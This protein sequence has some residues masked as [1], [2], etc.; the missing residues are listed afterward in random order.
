[1]FKQILTT[2]F[3]FTK[4]NING[5]IWRVL[6]TLCGTAKI[7]TTQSLLETY[8][9]SPA[10]FL[11]VWIKCKVTKNESVSA[12]TLGPKAS[13]AQVIPRPSSH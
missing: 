5:F 10:T 3:G 1:M 7:I 9:Y 12:S 6:N 8:T 11:T 13:W 4:I 2:K